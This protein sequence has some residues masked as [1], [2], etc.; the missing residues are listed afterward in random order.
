MQIQAPRISYLPLLLPELKRNFLPLL[1]EGGTSS[2]LK[3][4]GRG[5]SAEDGQG[6]E[7]EEG[8]WFSTE[9]GVALK[10]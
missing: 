2:A 10:W 7:E 9:E 1:E 4:K 5:S 8:W 6:H 3:G